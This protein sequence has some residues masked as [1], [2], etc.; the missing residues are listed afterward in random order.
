MRGRNGGANSGRGRDEGLAAAD[1]D[2][3]PLEDP[4]ILAPIEHYVEGDLGEH[5]GVGAH[6]DAGDDAGSDEP[7]ATSIDR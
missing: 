3:P 6:D 7:A 2:T 5:G 1:D 4:A